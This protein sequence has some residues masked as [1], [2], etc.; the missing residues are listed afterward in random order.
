MP[1]RHCSS[2]GW[3]VPDC[4]VCA[5]DNPRSAAT[6]ANCGAELGGADV[7]ATAPVTAAPEAGAFTSPGPP[8]RS[9]APV[10]SWPVEMA[11]TPAPTAREPEPRPVVTRRKGADL[12][13]ETTELQV[14]PG[15]AVATSL[16]VHNLGEEVERFTIEVNGPAGSFADA[17][18]A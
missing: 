13:L 17:E 5:F 3:P 12:A 10:Q 16:T 11:A 4:P 8:A 2:R 1:A 7:L 15:S 18:P 9:P 14:D 6:C